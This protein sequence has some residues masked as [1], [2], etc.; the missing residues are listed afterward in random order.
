[1]VKLK[2]ADVDMSWLSISSISQDLKT[3]D[4]TSST[5]QPIACFYQTLPV[6][7]MAMSLKLHTSGL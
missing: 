4:P 1:M 2:A 5:M 3:M 7:Y 6:C